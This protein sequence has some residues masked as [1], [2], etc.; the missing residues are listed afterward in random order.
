ME[1]CAIS[2]Q[3]YD[4]CDG[5]H[6]GA[7]IWKCG[8]C[9]GN[10]YNCVCPNPVPAWALD[11]RRSPDEYCQCPTAEPSVRRIDVLSEELCLIC[12]KSRR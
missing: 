10:V 5:N 1:I 7:C 3:L 12:E 2:N 6:E 8:D 4:D 9:G 11:P